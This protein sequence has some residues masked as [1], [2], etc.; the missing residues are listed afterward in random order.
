VELGVPPG[1]SSCKLY[2]Y[3]A[4][5]RYDLTDS[6]EGFLVIGMLERNRGLE[7][8][9]SRILPRELSLQ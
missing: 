4:L 6:P 9:Q 2:H 3:P 8:L 1:G 5:H 7:K